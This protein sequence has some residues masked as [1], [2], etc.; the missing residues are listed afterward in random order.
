MHRSLKHTNS[1]KSKDLRRK[2]LMITNTDVEAFFS[3]FEL[4]CISHMTTVNQ[5]SPSEAECTGYKLAERVHV[6]PPG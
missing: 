5:C 4:T 1:L 3:A 2:G 6:L